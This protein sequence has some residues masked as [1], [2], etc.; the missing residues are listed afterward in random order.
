M[1]VKDVAP[2]LTITSP[3]FDG[4]LFA[5]PATINLV[6]PFHR[7]GSRD[8]FECRIEWDE[9]SATFDPL[10]PETVFDAPFSGASGNCDAPVTS[11]RP[12]STQSG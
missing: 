1:T 3:S 11:K 4:E 5:A 10:E 7:P 12:V 8:R 9:G 6:T 2:D